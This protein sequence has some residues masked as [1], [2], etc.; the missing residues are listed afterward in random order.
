MV[1]AGKRAARR[2]SPAARDASGSPPT[3]VARR[4]ILDNVSSGE[5]PPDPGDQPPGP[6]DQP[7]DPGD[8]QPDPGAKQPPADDPFARLVLDEDFIK[9]A[10]ISEISAQA[11]QKSNRAMRRKRRKNLL[12]RLTHPGRWGRGAGG[13]RRAAGP[14]RPAGR[15]G[16]PAS[17]AGRQAGRVHL[18]DWTPAQWLVT[19]LAGVAVAAYLYFSL[20]GPT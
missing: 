11:R 3:A 16:R 9:S 20:G 12:S 7:P 14:G 15:A 19:T 4:A 17:G 1:A 10:S 6:G 18:P 8:R 13:G 2:R 5:P